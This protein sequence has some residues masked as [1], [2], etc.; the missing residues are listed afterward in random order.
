VLRVQ[1][2]DPKTLVKSIKITYLIEASNYDPWFIGTDYCH[3]LKRCNKKA[4][5]NN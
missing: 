3:I 4:L 2:H 5:R 1:T